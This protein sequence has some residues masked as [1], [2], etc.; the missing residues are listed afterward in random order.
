MPAFCFVTISVYNDS[1]EQVETPEQQPA[2][3]NIGDLGA[4]PY[5]PRRI[6]K[7]DFQA[8]KR[9]IQEFGDLSGVVF[10]RT[11]KRLVG[12][13][14]RIEAFKQL[15]QPTIVIEERLPT[16]N[17]VGTIA[18]GHV[19]LGDEKY[20]YREVEWEEQW[21]MAANIAANRI[22]GEFDKDKLAEVIATLEKDLHELTGLATA[23]IDA[24]LESV[25]AMGDTEAKKLLADKFIVPPFSILDTKAGY[26]QERSKAWGKI[27]GDTAATREGTL[28]MQSLSGAAYG[29]KEFAASGV[30]EFDP[31]LTEVAYR[32]FLPN[33]G[34]HILDPFGGSPVRSCVA[35]YLEHKYLG[36]ELRPEQAQATVDAINKV[37]VGQYASIVCADATKI[38]EVV[39]EQNQYDLVFTSPPFYDLEVY[40]D[41]PADLS[42]VGTY[43]EFWKMYTAA[44]TGAVARLRN[45][46]FVVVNVTEIRDKNGVYRNFVGDNVA[47]FRSLGL[48][49]YNDIIIANA[50]GTAAI[51][52]ARNMTSRKTV[53]V[54]QNL[55]VFYKGDPRNIKEQFGELA[56]EIP[57]GLDPTNWQENKPQ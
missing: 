33:A 3:N 57:E 43:E 25:G 41:N 45:E 12:G 56:G 16:I 21:E 17:S 27:L 8:L 7:P 28:G 32:W 18:R 36:I 54:H 20:T 38:T 49:F 23:E 24:L 31:V 42:N 13:H 15:Q 9:S 44:F 26:W 50:I 4:A 1:M 37:G 34:G 30:S 53:R 51:R 5:N 46:R 14:Q 2:T 39:P 52:A 48:H 47:L 40:S 19:L 22:Q 10:N 55:L 35:G 29:G 6:S 11:T